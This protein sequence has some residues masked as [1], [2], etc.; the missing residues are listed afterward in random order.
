MRMSAFSDFI[1]RW[2]T[3]SWHLVTPSRLKQD[4]GILQTPNIACSAWILQ[5]EE[6]E[7]DRRDMMWGN[8]VCCAVLRIWDVF[9][10]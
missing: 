2:I 3:E 8:A 4:I 6:V 7:V 9:R 1:D 5:S 10:S